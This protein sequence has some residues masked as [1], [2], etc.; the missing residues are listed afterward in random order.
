[1]WKLLKNCIP[2]KCRLQNKGVI[3]SSICPVAITEMKLLSNA[4]KL[5]KS[6]NYPYHQCF[7]CPLQITMMDH[8]NCWCSYLNSSD[9]SLACTICWAIWNDWNDIFHGRPS[10]NPSTKSSWICP[11]MK[12]HRRNFVLVL[13]LG[14]LPHVLLH[15]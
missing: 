6:G 1:M 9:L 4:T 2:T 15:L 10:P 13:I 8:W 5:K 7:H 3:C 11:T 14:L 12:N